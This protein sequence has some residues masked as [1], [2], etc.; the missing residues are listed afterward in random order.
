MWEAPPAL[1]LSQETRRCRAPARQKRMAWEWAPFCWR[2]CRATCVSVAVT[3]ARPVLTRSARGRLGGEKREAA[4]GG[5][6]AAPGTLCPRSGDFP[7]GGRG[8]HEE[9]KS[10][11]RSLASRSSEHPGIR[12]LP[13]KV[14]KPHEIGK[15]LGQG[16]SL[17][18]LRLPLCWSPQAIHCRRAAWPLPR[19]ARA[20]GSLTESGP[21]GPERR[22]ER[23]MQIERLGPAPSRA[24]APAP[25]CGRRWG[26][27][28]RTERTRRRLTVA[29][30]SSG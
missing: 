2:G 9:H 20:P 7:L 28:G 3:R 29:P 30:N 22:R 25:P 27:T 6:A 19:G 16:E 15:L 23:A 10:S 24:G 1:Q 26:G 12:C 13:M 8:A 21:G 5:G 17:F 11:V 14:Y 18:P 4:A